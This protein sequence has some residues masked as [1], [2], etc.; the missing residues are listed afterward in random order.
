MYKV[1]AS[2]TEMNGSVNIYFFPVIIDL[3]VCCLLLNMRWKSPHVLINCSAKLF[4]ARR[5]VT[6]SERHDATKL[7]ECQDKCSYYN[8]WS[9]LL[10]KHVPSCELSYKNKTDV[11]TWLVVLA[12][13]AKDLCYQNTKKTWEWAWVSKQPSRNHIQNIINSS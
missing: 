8:H 12:L 6:L 7:A 2:A 13:V 1:N 9:Y 5:C 11:R 10:C 4:S 3:L